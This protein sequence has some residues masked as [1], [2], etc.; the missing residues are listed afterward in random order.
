MDI[1]RKMIEPLQRRLSLMI[2]RCIVR[3]VTDSDGIQKMQIS[4]LRG[5]VHDDVERMQ[6]YGFTSVPKADAQALTVFVGGDREHGI[7][8]ACDDRRY[9][10]TGLKEGEVAIYTDEKDKIHF[11][12]NHEIDIKTFSP[13][14]ITID[15]GATGSEVKVVA[16]KVI[17]DSPD[18]N[19]GPALLPGTGVVTNLCS[20]AAYG[21]PHPVFSSTVKATL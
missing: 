13:G 4:A 21:N 20:C 16:G 14:K 18:V 10:I 6:N 11:K 3:L 2:G 17:V 19:L 15:A 8:V 1:L 5:E 7:V 12:R 9:R